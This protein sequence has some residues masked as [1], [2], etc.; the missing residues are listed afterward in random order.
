M[1]EDID[2]CRKRIA[3]EERLGDGAT[4]PEAGESHF[5]LAMLY[6]AQLATLLRN[7]GRMQA[8]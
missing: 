8:A 4:S 3:E 1:H 6:K 2:F 7:V 5:Q